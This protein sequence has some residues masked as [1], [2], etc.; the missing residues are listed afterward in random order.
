[1]A[2]TSSVYLGE[3]LY[4]SRTIPR[5]LLSHA[6]YKHVV[7]H[8]KTRKKE[9]LRNI[10]DFIQLFTFASIDIDQRLFV[11]KCKNSAICY[12]V[13]IWRVALRLR[14]MIYPGHNKIQ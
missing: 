4:V 10:L 6:P 12:L 8:V 5:Y 3:A 9:N 11:L 14:V 7:A 1:M 13:R 2:P